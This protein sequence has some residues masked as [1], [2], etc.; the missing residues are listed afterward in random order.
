MLLID[1]QPTQPDKFVQFAQSRVM[2]EITH[3]IPQ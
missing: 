2:I 1:G 3:L